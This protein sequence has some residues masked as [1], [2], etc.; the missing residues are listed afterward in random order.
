MNTD[1]QLFSRDD[2]SPE[3]LDRAERVFHE[4]ESR[5]SRFRSDSELS[6][7]NN[8][9]GS[10]VTVSPQFFQVLALAL[11]YHRV[12]G[13]IFDPAVLPALEAA[14]YDRSFESVPRSSAAPEPSGG[15]SGKRHSIAALQLD[16]RGRTVTAPSGLRIDLGGI[17]KGYAVDLAACVLE[18]G[19]DFMIDAGGDIFASGDGPEGRGWPVAVASP[20]KPQE[21]VA[22]LRL[23]DQALAT[24]TT[25]VRRWQRGGSWINHI[26]DPRSGQPAENG[27]VSVSVVAPTATR[28]DVYAKTAL[29]L[30]PKDGRLFLEA[31]QTPGLFVLSDGTYRE[32]RDW[33]TTIQG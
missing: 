10:E 26:I 3:L 11:H 32:T 18:P 16:P 20:Y 21:D 15:T 19:H 6:L 4:V 27:T 29:L 28:A 13:G 12:T 2:Q 24:S 33:A 1:I 22:V 31:Q 23:H 14:G 9:S 17:G 25:A 30:G 8:R 5:L 7:L